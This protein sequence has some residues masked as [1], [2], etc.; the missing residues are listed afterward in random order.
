MQSPST[1]SIISRY[2]LH[3]KKSLGQHFLTNQSITDEIVRVAGN[4]SE[5]IVVEIGP[6]P[7]CLTQAILA[8]PA[9]KII[10][11]EHDTR[12]VEAL[13]EAVV[14]LA[15]GRL[16]VIEADALHTSYE[17]S[18]GYPVT[19]IANLPYNISTQL[20]LKW[21]DHL[22][23]IQSMTLMFQKEV[24]E[25]IGAEPHTKSYGKL[26]VLT[27]RLC[28]VVHHFDLPKEAFSPPPNVLSSVISIIPRPKPLVDIDP[29]LLSSVLGMLFNQRRKM[30]RKSV[31]Q[32]VKQPEPLLESLGINPCDRI[33]DLDV[34]T[35]CDLVN[36]IN[37]SYRKGK[38]S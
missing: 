4:L 9:K 37:L 27:Q 17:F 36:A 24:A 3:T 26:S 30:L 14:P 6:G 21:L 35:I 2:G 11:I 33:E 10:A 20:L 1:Q 7:G 32:C 28:E 23:Q 15:E 16:D 18:E 31:H 8:S 13:R 34:I 29:K 22:P 5:K 19:I 38:N 25:R 12:C